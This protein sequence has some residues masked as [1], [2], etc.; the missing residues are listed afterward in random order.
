M[1]AHFKAEHKNLVLN[2]PTPKCPKTFTTKV[3]LDKH[4]KLEEASK[5]FACFASTCNKVYSVANQRN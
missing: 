5:K 1:V 2:C 3:D 4:I